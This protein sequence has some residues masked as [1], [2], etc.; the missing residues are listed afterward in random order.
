MPN[1]WKLVPMEPTFEMI[2]AA[3]NAGALAVAG[4][5]YK[6]MLK[7]APEAPDYTSV[8]QQAVEALRNAHAYS[9]TREEFE[10]GV[11]DVIAALRAA[12]GEHDE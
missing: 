10:N 7:A 6:A 12:L 2:K 5:S 9:T 3:Y 11:L 8:M 1:T 4:R